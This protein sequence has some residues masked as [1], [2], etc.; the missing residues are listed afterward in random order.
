MCGSPTKQ[1][2]ADLP[3][4]LSEGGGIAPLDLT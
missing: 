3:G 1:Q 4:H 2:V